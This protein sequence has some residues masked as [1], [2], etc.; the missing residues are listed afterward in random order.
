MTTKEAK[1]MATTLASIITVDIAAGFIT[2]KDEDSAKNISEIFLVASDY[3]TGAYT[4]YLQ[5]V[6]GFPQTVYMVDIKLPK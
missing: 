1:E 4:N 5:N 6:D 3:R 2:V